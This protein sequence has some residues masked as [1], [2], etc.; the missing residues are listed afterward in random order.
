MSPLAAAIATEM[1]LPGDDARAVVACWW[2]AIKYEET[3]CPFVVTLAKRAG[4]RTTY[5]EMQMWEAAML[6]RIGFIIPRWNVARTIFETLG[7][8]AN[9]WVFAMLY[10]G[11]ADSR[12]AEDWIRVLRMTSSTMPVVLQILSAKVP[13]AKVP[14]RLKR[15]SD[16]LVGGVALVS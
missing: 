6:H 13:F 1:I 7:P 8:S 15:K 9:L 5:K 4:V 12:A 16:C 11:V 14:R 2:V 10:C 3:T